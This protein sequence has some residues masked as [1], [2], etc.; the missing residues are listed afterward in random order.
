MNPRD[1]SAQISSIRHAINFVENEDIRACLEQAIKTLEWMAKGELVLKE[2]IPLRKENPELFE[3]LR[4][5]FGMGARLSD[6]R[7][8]EDLAE[9]MGL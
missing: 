8:T 3:T 4:R 7:A 9:R 6:I 2:L 5:L 1:L